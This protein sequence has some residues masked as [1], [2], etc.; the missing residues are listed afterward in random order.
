MSKSKDNVL[1]PMPLIE[2]FGADGLRHWACRA[3]PGADTA[4]ESAQMRVGRRLAVKILNASKFALGLS[5]EQ[6]T[7]ADVTEALDRAMLGRLAAVVTSATEDFLSYDYHRALE[8]TE[9]FFWSFCDDYI[10]L[11]KTRAYQG[12]PA[13]RSAQAALSTALSVVL[14]LFAPFLPFVTEEVWSWWQAGSV[15][16]APW[17]TA[18]EF[19][20]V[21]GDAAPTLLDVAGALLSDIRKAKSAERRSQ[22]HE[23]LSVVVED[24]PDVIATLLL[25]E[26]D[27]K[28]AG[29]VQDLVAKEGA[30]RKVW[31]QLAP[32]AAGG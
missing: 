17:P 31:V 29:V 28:H 1:A 32:D 30:E 23:V 20:D 5:A 3:A 19:S 2:Q 26:A 10:E 12:G 6:T 14:R 21:V 16:R 11:V 24:E 8:R 15:H 4:A 25:A 22:R 7:L 13:G 18:S 27:L 9:T